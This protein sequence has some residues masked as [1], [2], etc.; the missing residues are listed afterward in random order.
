[1]RG[2][3]IQKEE[4]GQALGNKAG[5]PFDWLIPIG[6]DDSTEEEDRVDKIGGICAGVG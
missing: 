6:D 2:K 5:D 3:R 1:V 4:Q